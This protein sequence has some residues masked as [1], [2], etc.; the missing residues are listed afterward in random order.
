MEDKHI[1]ELM[2][3][4]IDWKYVTVL[5]KRKMNRKDPNYQIIV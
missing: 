4:I 5:G 1:Q 3:E 2:E